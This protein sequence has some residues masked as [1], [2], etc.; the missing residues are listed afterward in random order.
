MWLT[1]DAA[2]AMSALPLG[3]GLPRRRW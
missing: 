1:Q 2:F 3:F